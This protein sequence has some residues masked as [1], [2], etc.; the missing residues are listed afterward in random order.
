MDWDSDPEL[1]AIRD[2]FL[3]SLTDRRKMLAI[4]GT[5]LEDAESDEARRSVLIELQNLAHKLGGTAESYGFPTVTVAACCLDE[6]L[7]R[8]MSDISGIGNEDYEMARGFARLLEDIVSA[9]QNAGDPRSFLEDE[10]TEELIRLSG[11]DRTS[12]RGLQ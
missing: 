4:L 6:Y 7:E 5:E 10:R 9:A 12:F 3:A 2:E 1:K 8:L 11:V